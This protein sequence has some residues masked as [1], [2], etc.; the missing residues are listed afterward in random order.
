[1]KQYSD[2][3][4]LKLSRGQKFLYRL[5]RFLLS[6]PLGIG[7][8]F[9]K[10]FRALGKGI[11]GIGVTASESRLD[12][13]GVKR[14]IAIARRAGI[15][16]FALFDLDETLEKEILPALSGESGESRQ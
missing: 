15:A 12:A 3:E 7:R 14:Q 16:G 9:M 1:M 10:I 5:Q 13:E 2:L 8:F 11:A 4:F 6:I